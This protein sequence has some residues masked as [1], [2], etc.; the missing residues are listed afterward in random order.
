MP[1]RGPGGR[2]EAGNPVAEPLQQVGPQSLPGGR[3]ERVRIARDRHH[4]LVALQQQSDKTTP[5]GGLPIPDQLPG[6]YVLRVAGMNGVVTRKV[7]KI[8]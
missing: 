4:E 1:Q 3:I 6:I 2:D 5:A 8:H 7:V